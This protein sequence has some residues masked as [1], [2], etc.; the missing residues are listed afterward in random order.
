VV[1][2][3]VAKSIDDAAKVAATSLSDRFIPS[4]PSIPSS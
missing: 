1:R 3:S 4:F 2:P